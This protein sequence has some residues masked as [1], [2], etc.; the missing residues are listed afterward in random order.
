MYTLVKKVLSEKFKSLD[1]PYT[2][3]CLHLLLC[4]AHLKREKACTMPST[5]IMLI[6]D[7][8]YDRHA[9][10]TGIIDIL[11]D[12]RYPNHTLKTKNITILERMQSY[13]DYKKHTKLMAVLDPGS[14]SK[15]A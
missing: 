10:S 12:S 8:A 4:F 15:T 13:P 1:Q 2:A 6:R 7:F 5:L 9:A 3:S 11:K 14:W